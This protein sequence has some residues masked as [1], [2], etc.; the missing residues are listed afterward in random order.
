MTSD[1]TPADWA[2][3]LK[4]EWEARAALPSRDL[5]VASHVGWTDPSVWDRTAATEVELFLAGLD[6]AWL[7][8]EDVL[9]I[10]CGSGR[11][12]RRLRAAARS[13][14]GYDIAAGMVE[15]ARQ[16]AGDTE[17]VRFF[18]G[19]GL[20]VP[21]GAQ[22]RQYGLV[23]AVAVFIHCPRAVIATNV[24]N[25]WRSV[26]PGG[27]LRLSVLAFHDDPEGIV[28][29]QGEVQKATE[30]LAED[31]AAV[32]AN[33]TPEERRLAFDTYYMGDRFRY[34]E[35][36]PFLQQLTGGAVA[37]YRGDPGAIYAAVTRPAG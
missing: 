22:D 9:E 26:R 2:S 12:A 37:L 23:L 1:S 4:K 32:I 35:M 33:L 17:G 29:P 7:R 30:V 31:M 18:V 20:T 6:A 24:Q 27:Q 13:Y 15:A 16:R 8:G 5:F 19:D 10:G 28:G 36:A 21:P 25:A 3:L 14:T 11:L 34:A